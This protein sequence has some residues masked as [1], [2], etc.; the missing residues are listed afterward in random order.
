MGACPREGLYTTP[1]TAP[2]RT[3]HAEQNIPEGIQNLACFVTPSITL[4]AA[5]HPLILDGCS[6]EGVH[7]LLVPLIL[8]R[9]ARSR[10]D[11]RAYRSQLSLS[12]FV[13]GPDG[14]LHFQLQLLELRL[15]LPSQFCQVPG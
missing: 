1:P 9:L 6:Q 2:A 13:L 5:G 3:L 8:R 15:V 4:R 12:L 14:F 10:A 11:G 7:P